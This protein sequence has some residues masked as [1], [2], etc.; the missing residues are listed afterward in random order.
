VLDVPA[1]RPPHKV[2][3][4]K[5]LLLQIGILTI[6]SGCDSAPVGEELRFVPRDP[7]DPRVYVTNPR[8]GTLALAPESPDG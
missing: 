5:L 3:Q 6:A 8:D 7:G 1:P 4:L 2:R